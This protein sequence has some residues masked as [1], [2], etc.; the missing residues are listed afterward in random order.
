MA[1][2]KKRSIRHKIKGSKKDKKVYKQKI[3]AKLKE[4][5]YVAEEKGGEVIV[6]AMT[7]AKA[8]QRYRDAAYTVAHDE[9]KKV[10]Q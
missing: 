2:K 5:G 6:R 8:D 7:P 1:K 10:G 4:K 3:V 9:L